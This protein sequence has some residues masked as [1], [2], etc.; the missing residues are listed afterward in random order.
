MSHL[1]SEV[2]QVFPTFNL[3]QE[4]VLTHLS[5]SFSAE[6]GESRDLCEYP[7]CLLPQEVGVFTTGIWFQVGT[8]YRTLIPSENSIGRERGR[9]K[10]G[11]LSTKFDP[12]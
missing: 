11:E 6:A 8:E 7:T 10:L 4:W 5:S 3:L 9:V 12:N 2:L 1:I